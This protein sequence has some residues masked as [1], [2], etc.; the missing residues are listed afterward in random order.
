MEKGRDF[1]ST[2]TRATN[3]EGI[4]VDSAMP[5][6]AWQAFD[7]GRLDDEDPMTKLARFGFGSFDDYGTLLVRDILS[8]LA[9]EPR[10]DG[11]KK[12][13][14]SIHRNQVIDQRWI[15]VPKSKAFD[16]DDRRQCW[17]WDFNGGGVVGTW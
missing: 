4:A 9:P 2:M 1:L 6:F 12:S 3:G 7:R 15:I 14:S 17:K 16:G 11:R 5:G 10:K 8:T 13:C